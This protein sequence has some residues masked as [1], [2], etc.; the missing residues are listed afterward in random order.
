MSKVELLEPILETGIR[1]TNFFN[2]RL[3]TAEDLRAEQD[4]GREQRQHLGRAIG[5]GIAYGLEVSRSESLSPPSAS[6][7]RVAAGLAINRLGQALF[8]A[9]D[10]DV[11]LTRER[12]L[13]GEEA[14]AFSTCDSQPSTLIPAGTGVYILVMTPASGF[15]GRAPASG[16]G[17]T[18]FTGG[19]CG[20]RYAVEGVQF[21]L[22]GLNITSLPNVSQSL[23]NQ[24]NQLLVANDVAS[25]AR[26]RN[27]LAHLCFGTENW[28][29]LAGNLFGSLR[30]ETPLDLF[31]VLSSLRDSGQLTDCDVPLAIIFWT[32]SD[33]SFIDLWSVRRNI[34][35][36]KRERGWP[37]PFRSRQLR[38]REAVALQFQESISAISDL[39]TPAQRAAARADDYFLYLPPCGLLPI[40]SGG[41][42]PA[43]FFGSR[44]R[45]LEVVL[46]NRQWRSLLDT[47][48]DHDPIETAGNQQICLFSVEENL[49]AAAGIQRYALFASRALADEF[50]FPLSIR[51]GGN[52]LDSVSLAD[53][54]LQT[55][56]RY[57]GL[58]TIIV[59]SGGAF[60]FPL[61]S[62]DHLGLMAI[63]QV[64][65]MALGLEAQARGRSL[66]QEEAI[67]SFTALARAEQHFTTTFINT[68][69]TQSFS[70][71]Y[72]QNFRNMIVA[73]NE[74]LIRTTVSAGITGLFR[75]LA[76]ND[77]LGAAATQRAINQRLGL[78]VGGTATGNVDV[79]F[80]DV[81]P[82]PFQEGDIINFQY[83][84][85]TRANIEETYDLIPNIE[86]DQQQSLWQSRARFLGA[87]Q[88]PLPSP[89]IRMAAEE[90]ENV[91]L[92]INGV[93]A[94]TVGSEIR[95]QLVVR[96][97]SNPSQ[98]VGTSSEDAFT[99]GQQTIPP[100]SDITITFGGVQG[101]SSDASGRV[102]VPTGG[103]ATVTLPLRLD[104]RGQYQLT[105]A[106][107]EPA[108]SEWTMQ[109]LLP[110]LPRTYDTRAGQIPL[111]QNIRIGL[112]PNGINSRNTSLEVRVEAI[113]DSTHGTT[114]RLPIGVG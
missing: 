48:F 82:S 91:F 102:L 79:S 49:Q 77:L 87:D 46:H 73:V 29:G 61:S 35:Y 86:A 19:S 5:E 59:A 109:I 20:S 42:D 93:P 11:A 65:A 105:A 84:I 26:L 7:V 28:L 33:P 39:L 88:V 97:A 2:G 80:L 10:T 104:S 103:G 37:V 71:R 25:R 17:S 85:Q 60:Q 70:A 111:N 83:Q 18:V 43:T 67:T 44:L 30:S 89:S 55:A 72:T 50:R 107:P 51:R 4:A 81:S 23:R 6:S 13:L 101:G 38:L 68:V 100:A 8:L 31:G 1:N 12:Q 110:A 66:T 95:L 52:S 3:L 58:Q 99:V 106:I 112:L 63:D 57:Q 64:V 62:P 24:I 92:Q 27:A 53:L 56:Q 41:F 74:L 36:I 96:S 69:L 76:N 114:F 75:A 98:L 16:L 21:R 15:S 40:S 47:S 34:S 78:Q 94:G 113:N 54:F 14:G 90:I 32:G 45:G 22:V 9:E 108:T